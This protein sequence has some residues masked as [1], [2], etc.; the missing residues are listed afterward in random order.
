MHPWATYFVVGIDCNERRLNV[1][2]R[3]EGTAVS[4][5]IDID[6]ISRT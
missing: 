5:K 3:K 6:M 1:V 2:V 4:L